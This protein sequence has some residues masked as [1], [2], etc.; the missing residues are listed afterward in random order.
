[1]FRYSLLLPFH[2]SP[3]LRSSSFLLKELWGGVGTGGEGLG[4]PWIFLDLGDVLTK[5]EVYFVLGVH[6]S[7]I[8]RIQIVK[9]LSENPLKI[10][11]LCY[12]LGSLP[13][14]PSLRLIL[15]HLFW[16]GRGGR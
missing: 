11:I 10:H 14:A 2:L 5:S 8:F 13:S 6:L 7:L 4:Q 9:G 16:L 12:D 1:M 15:G 3:T